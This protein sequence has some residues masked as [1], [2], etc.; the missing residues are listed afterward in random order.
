M[1]QE[2]K[3]AMCSAVPFDFHD[4]YIGNYISGDGNQLLSSSS[5]EGG[6]KRKGSHRKMHKGDWNVWSWIRHVFGIDSA[7]VGEG[8]ILKCDIH[9]VSF[10][11]LSFFFC[12]VFAKKKALFSEKRN[13]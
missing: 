11:P 13:V 8:D 10:F 5:L 4:E 9:D 12:F 6:R 3:D 7:H 2:G 1:A